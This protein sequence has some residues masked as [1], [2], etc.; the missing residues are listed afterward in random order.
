VIINSGAAIPLFAAAAA[1]RLAHMCHA[2]T[3]LPSQAA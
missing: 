3:V 1:A 2:R